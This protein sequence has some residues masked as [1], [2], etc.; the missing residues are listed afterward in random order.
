MYLS[1]GTHDLELF[2]STMDRLM[3]IGATSSPPATS[4]TPTIS[5][6][7]ATVGSGDDKLVGGGEEEDAA[8]AHVR[9]PRFDKSLRGGRGDRAPKEEWTVVTG[10]YNKCEPI[11]ACVSRLCYIFD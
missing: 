2:R 11:D 10:N 1:A 6:A 5:P 3:T 9:V 8:H 4:T 7:A